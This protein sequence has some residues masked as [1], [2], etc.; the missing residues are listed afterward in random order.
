[1]GPAAGELASLGAKALAAAI[2]DLCPRPGCGSHT[3]PTPSNR[4]Q[5]ASC[6]KK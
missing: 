1:M 3:L 5:G 2:P 4:A 6:Q